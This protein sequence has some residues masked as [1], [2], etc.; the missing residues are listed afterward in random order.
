LTV[1]DDLTYEQI[2]SRLECTYKE[3]CRARF[4]RSRRRGR[5][6]AITV[7]ENN[8]IKNA[9]EDWAFKTYLK[10]MSEQIFKPL[11]DTD[12]RNLMYA[13]FQC[14]A[15]YFLDKGYSGIKYKSTV[16]ESAKDIVLFDKTY[17]HPVGDIKDFII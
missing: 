9:V 14:V 13:P 6:A 5:A 11:E 4:R 17:A 7:A 16:C 2:N 8:K 10:L 3:I 12:D 15:Q 1:A